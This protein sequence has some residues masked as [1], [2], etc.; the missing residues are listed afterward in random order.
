[1]SGLNPKLNPELFS[2]VLGIIEPSR[3]AA[4]QQLDEDAVLVSDD[5]DGEQ[6]TIP[7]LEEAQEAHT[8]IS[9]AELLN[10]LSEVAKGVSDGTHQEYLRYASP[11]LVLFMTST[12]D[13]ACSFKPH[14]AL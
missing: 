2:G 1:M 5:L 6:E 11:P 13:D 10:T 3:P 4:A 8:G 9:V 7:N 14:K 12:D